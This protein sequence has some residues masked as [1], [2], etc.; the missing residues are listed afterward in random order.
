M[1]CEPDV[2]LPSVPVLNLDGY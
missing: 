1:I 2:V